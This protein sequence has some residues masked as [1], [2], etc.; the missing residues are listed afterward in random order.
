MATVNFEK[1]VEILFNE[2]PSEKARD[3]VKKIADKIRAKG[4][5]WIEAHVHDLHITDAEVSDQSLAPI[6]DNRLFYLSQWQLA[7]AVQ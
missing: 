1:A 6:E 4:D 7:L 5:E 2:A 3:F